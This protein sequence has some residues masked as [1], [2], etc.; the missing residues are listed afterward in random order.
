LGLAPARGQTGPEG[1]EA[2]FQVAQASEAQ[3]QYAWTYA[4]GD[5]EVMLE[6]GHKLPAVGTL[7][8]RV[9]AGQVPLTVVVFNSKRGA[10]ERTARPA[11]ESLEPGKEK[12]MVIKPAKDPQYKA[13]VAFLIDGSKESLEMKELSQTWSTRQVSGASCSDLAQVLY[14]RAV[15]WSSEDKGGANLAGD[16]Q[17]EVGAVRSF[18]P[19]DPLTLPAG[20]PENWPDKARVLKWMPG[21]HPVVISRF[22]SRS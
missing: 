14:D 19:R 13:Y 3:A 20:P 5:R 1:P 16:V 18:N 17:N 6:P 21:K 8:L 22:A 7:F 11:V 12:R 15:L 2:V 9:K 4:D 10:M